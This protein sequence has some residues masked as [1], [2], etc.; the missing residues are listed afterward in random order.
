M[1]DWEK[2]GLEEV[3]CFCNNVTKGDIIDA[4]ADGAETLEQVS[5]FNNAGN[6]ADCAAKNPSGKCCRDDIQAILDIYVAAVKGV[7][8]SCG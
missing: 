5:T 2:A 7:Q 6:G 8:G 4:I 1:K 3:V